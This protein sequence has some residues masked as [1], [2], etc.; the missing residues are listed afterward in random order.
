MI[1]KTC[2][3][4]TLQK[5]SAIVLGNEHRGVSKEAEELADERFLIPMRGFVQSLNVS[6]AA[7]VILYEAQRQRQEKGFY[8]KSDLPEDKLNELIETWCKK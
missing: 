7:A 6:V 5:R 1:Q 2:T 8:E 4:L 3:S